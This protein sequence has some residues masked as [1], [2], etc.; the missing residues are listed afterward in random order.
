MLRENKAGAF[1]VKALKHGGSVRA[2]SATAASQMHEAMKRLKVDCLTFPRSYLPDLLSTK[3]LEKP[4][5]GKPPTLKKSVREH[6]RARGIKV[7]YA[8]GLI[9]FIK[10][11]PKQNPNI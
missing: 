9:D 2:I 7:V 10:I 11:V 8:G 6:L 3:A 5:G 4:K 1:Q